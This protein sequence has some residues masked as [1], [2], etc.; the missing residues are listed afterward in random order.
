MVNKVSF[1]T[2]E[3]CKTCLLSNQYVIIKVSATWCGPC[4]RIASLVEACLAELPSNVVVIVVDFDAHRD[5]ARALKINNVPTFMFYTNGAPGICLAGGN[6]QKV[7]KFFQDVN[8]QI[9]G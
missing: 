9:R 6:K 5:V 4:K 3:E 8:A 7:Q 2:R 1:K